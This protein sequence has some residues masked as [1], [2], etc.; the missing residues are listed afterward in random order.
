MLAD[1]SLPYAIK[2]TL[3]ILL[4]LC[5]SNS[6]LLPHG[7]LAPPSTGI[8]APALYPPIEWSGNGRYFYLKDRTSGATLRINRRGFTPEGF[9]VSIGGK[10]Y[11][12]LDKGG[13]PIL[14]PFASRLKLS[15][16]D[17]GRSL[18]TLI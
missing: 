15:R 13:S 16:G 3:I 4:A 12:L 9:T 18:K 14:F 8:D 1:T 6:A 5:L 17:E 7:M 10:E 11:N 2:K